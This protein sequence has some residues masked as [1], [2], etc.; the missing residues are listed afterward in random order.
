MSRGITFTA[1]SIP[2]L[3]DDRKTQTRRVVKSQGLIPD[4]WKDWSDEA[5]AAVIRH[6]CPYGKVGGHLWVKETWGLRANENRQPFEIYEVLRGQ[7]DLLRRHVALSFQ[8][9]AEGE[10]PEMFW[11][12]SRFMPKRVA[13]IW[14][15]IVEIRVE[16]LQDIY[17]S[18]EDMEAEGISAVTGAA[19]HLAYEFREL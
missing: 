1:E 18:P 5:K 3:L 9:R 14:L 11:R 19:E 7:Y 8:Y 13:R 2:S 10:D 4:D 17:I 12:S 15:E 16:H 6:K